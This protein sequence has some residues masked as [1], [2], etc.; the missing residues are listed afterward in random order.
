MTVFRLG[1]KAP[2][3]PAADDYWIAPTATVVGDVWLARGASVWFGAVVRGD[4][5][6]ITVGERSN[7]QDGAVLHSDPGVP[8]VIGADVTVGHLAMI[9]SCTIGDGCLVGIGAVILSRAVLG[10]HCLVGAGAV[11]TE[12][13]VFPD[14]SLIVGAPA[15]AVRELSDEQCAFLDAS[16]AHY[17]SNWRRYAR[18][19]RSA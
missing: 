4:N 15:R 3:L 11:V 9:H 1:D 10:R 18:D 14:R 16:A 2:R 8:L 6:P 19:L 17:V 7:V 12:R 13:K 5:D